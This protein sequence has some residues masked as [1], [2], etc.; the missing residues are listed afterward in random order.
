M[1]YSFNLIQYITCSLSLKD[2]YVIRESDQNVKP[3]IK[4]HDNELRNRFFQTFWKD[5]GEL[6]KFGLKRLSF[7]HQQ[8][9]TK[10]WWKSMGDWNDWKRFII[11]QCWDQKQQCC[12]KMITR[13]S[14]GKFEAIYLV[15]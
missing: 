4:I 2:Y 15:K 5:K 6:N 10:W 8:K 12:F 14:Q 1:K 9:N 3:S 7:F 13:W 11:V